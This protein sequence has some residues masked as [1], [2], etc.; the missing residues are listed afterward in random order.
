MCF[1][2]IFG[3]I[4]NILE[5]FW[6]KFQTQQQK[7]AFCAAMCREHFVPGPGR[8][9]PA[10]RAQGWNIPF[11]GTPHSDMVPHPFYTPMR[12]LLNCAS[13]LVCNSYQGLQPRYPC[14]DDSGWPSDGSAQTPP[15]QGE[16]SLHLPI[17]VRGI[18][19]QHV[20]THV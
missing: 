14:R 16:Q 5:Q 15:T 20:C 18:I 10:H 13:S 3:S 17:E 4:R 1:C 7:L 6:D 9:A 12:V 2:N 11:R 19:I 8:R